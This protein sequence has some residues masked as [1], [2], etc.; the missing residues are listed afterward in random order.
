MST[1]VLGEDTITLAELLEQLGGVPVERVRFRHPLGSATEEEYVRFVEKTKRGCELI[2]GVIVEKAMGYYE[3]RL[4]MVLGRVLGNFLVQ[5]PLGII[6]GESGMVRI[7]GQVRMPDVAFY[8]LSAFPSGRLPRTAILGAT[9]TLAVEVISPSNTEGEMERKRH[10]CFQAGTLL[11]WEVYPDERRVR[12]YT[13]EV[14]FTDHGVTDTLDGAPAIPGFTISIRQW[15][16]EAGER[17]PA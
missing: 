10:D 12:V 14:T 9:P 3:S 15:F 7:E 11:F 8:P 16:D 5:N 17:D 2:D 13:D 4:A 1:V 6:L